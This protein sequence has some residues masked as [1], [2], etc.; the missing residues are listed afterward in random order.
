MYITDRCVFKLTDK[1]LKLTEVAPGI[2]IESQILAYMDFKPIIEDD[3]KEMD[4]RIF[5]E[6]LVGLKDII[7]E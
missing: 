5:Q 1:G 6:G 3:V 4:P 2:D 7:T